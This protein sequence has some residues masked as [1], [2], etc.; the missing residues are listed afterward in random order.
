M[1]QSRSM[2]SSFWDEAI[3]CANY[4]QNW[5]PYKAIQHMTPEEAWSHDKLDVFFFLSIWQ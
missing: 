3:N 5:M 4:I 2:D 1:I